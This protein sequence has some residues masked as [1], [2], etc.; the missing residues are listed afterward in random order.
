[1]SFTDMNKGRPGVWTNFEAAAV[2]AVEGSDGTVAIV[3]ENY[4]V[5]ATADT[6]YAFTLQSEAE[7]IIGKSKMDDIVWAFRGGAAKVIVYTKP[8]IDTYAKAQAALELQFFESLTF[9]HALI[10][11]DVTAWKTWLTAQSAE[12]NYRELFYGVDVDTDVTAAIARSTTDNS[13]LISN[14]INAP[15]FGGTVLTSAQI[16]PYAAG[17]YASTPISSSITYT[18][19]PDATDVNVRL[20]S[21][22]IKNALAAGAIVFEYNG[23][24][25]RL[26][27]GVATNGT[28]LKRVAIK[29]QLAR[30][31][32]FLIE[33][34]YIGKV[35]NGPNE[36]LS[37]RGELKDYLQVWEDRSIIE[38]DNWYV[39]VIQ[40]PE[41]RQ[42]V[43]NA[44]MVDLETMEEIYITVG[45]GA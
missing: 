15:K 32:K 42:V 9:D 20:T 44:F 43:V 26:V 11:A 24:N 25:V 22:Q 38:P 14:V 23:R 10:P 28:S 7:A 4:N 16:A 40:G 31:W 6:V 30:D 41:K 18:E 8:A 19:V 37:Q 34:K 12:E 45:L 2:A 3:K 21:P 35:A 39:N 17:L 27:R 5:T 36:R 1:M 33:T 13:E 29:Q